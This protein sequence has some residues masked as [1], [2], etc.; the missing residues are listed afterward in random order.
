MMP[1]A[2]NKLRIAAGRALKGSILSPPPTVPASYKN[3]TH[4]VLYSSFAMR[5]GMFWKARLVFTY[6]LVTSILLG[7]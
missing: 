3:G 5:Y 2:A 6:E 4:I 1:R 7:V